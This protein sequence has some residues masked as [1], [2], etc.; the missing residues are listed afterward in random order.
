[1]QSP[2]A[3]IVIPV[4][5]STRPIARAVAS[6]VDGSDRDVHVIVVAHNIEASVIR[7]NLGAYAG[8]ENVQLISLS[9]GIPSPAGPMNAGIDAAVAPLVG[10]MGSDDTLE[11][12]AVDS[13]IALH[14]TTGATAVLAR[15]CQAGGAPDPYPPVRRGRRTRNLSAVRDRLSY[16]SAPLGLVLRDAHPGLRFSVGLR[17]GED[18]EYSATLWFEGKHLAYDLRGPAYVVNDDATDRVT[19][20]PR[21]VSE[22]FAFLDRIAATRWFPT[23]SRA[24][25]RALLVKVMRVH[26][27]DAVLARTSLTNGVSDLGDLRAV[28]ARIERLAPGTVAL[29]S[30]ADRAVLDELARPEPDAA[31]ILHALDARWNYRTIAAMCPRNPLLALS[32][33]GPFRTLFAGARAASAAQEDARPA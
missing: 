28:V 6:V 16:R 24:A 18:L 14:E 19:G 25:R 11:P 21:P 9:D 8:H 12:H 4:H 30:R 20:E 15:I 10:V 32:T 27:F 33:Q 17:S 13:W 7:A 5:S 3:Q 29:L 26:L 23:L 1:M 31:A 2:E 22:D